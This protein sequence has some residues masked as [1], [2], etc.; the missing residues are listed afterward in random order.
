ML[1]G[2]VGSEHLSD[3]SEECTAGHK[4]QRMS[5]DQAM[6]LTKFLLS[7]M[8]ASASK[9]LLNDVVMKSVETTASSV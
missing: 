5:A 1:P 9:M 6:S 2:R 3:P 7:E 4:R 8:P